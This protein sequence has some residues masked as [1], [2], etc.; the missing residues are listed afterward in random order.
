VIETLIVSRPVAPPWNDSGKNLVRDLVTHCTEVQHRVLSVRGFSLDLGHVTEEP[1]YTSDDAFRPKLADQAR[2]FARL[3]RPGG[4]RIV[5]FVLPWEDERSRRLARV[6]LSFRHQAVVQTLLT[7]PRSSAGMRK[8]LFGNRI[9]T[10]SEHTTRLLEAAG[11]PGVVH[12]PPGVT[13]PQSSGTSDR[14]LFREEFDL[15]ADRPVVVYPG[16]YGASRAAETFAEAVEKLA[17]VLDVTFVFACRHKRLGD[18]AEEGRLRARLAHLVERRRVR[19]VGETDRIRGLLAAADLVC[20]PAASSSGM[21]DI[22]LVLLEALAAGTPV[23]VGDV[24]PM[25]EVLGTHRQRPE[26]P[27]GQAVDPNDAEAVATAIAAM[28]CDRDALR[29]MGKAGRKWIDARF[30]ARYMGAAH[31]MLYLSLGA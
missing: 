26:R 7:A 3:L 29:E 24:A 17:S 19:F 6:A 11:V 22:P 20:L 10:L 25:N 21:T 1:I 12:I 23:L 8:R 14:A 5:H 31:E 15:A 13:P 2:V 27:V 4:R 9:V 30:H 28:V 16:D 18:E